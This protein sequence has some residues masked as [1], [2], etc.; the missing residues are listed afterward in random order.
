LGAS[1]SGSDRPAG[2]PRV[3]AAGTRLALCA[4]A[5][6]AA[7]V[8][9]GT[10]RGP[11]SA[12]PDRAAAPPPSRDLP[13][14]V[15]PTIG[16]RPEAGEEDPVLPLVTLVPS[17]DGAVTEALAAGL[18]LAFERS[19]GSGGPDLALRIAA[20]AARWSSAADGAVRDGIEA[21]A[22]AIV[23]P[24][25]R[26]HAHLLAQL[27]TRLRCPVLS[28]SPA[29]GV[30]AAGS[31]YVAAVVPTRGG[32]GDGTPVAPEFDAA[33]PAAAGFVEAFRAAHG[34]A[35][36]PWEAVGYDAGLCA[37]EAVRVHGL[38]RRGF[39]DAL[40]AAPPVAGAAWRL[41]IARNGSCR[42]EEEAGTAGSR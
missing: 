36:G 21:G 23:A 13:A 32:V 24:P 38:R 34:R 28:T 11:A 4:L 25:E 35:P 10:V 5:A 9:E 22:V 3:R 12:A 17:E 33:S 1:S 2:R 18:R 37:L 19:R 30:V 8:G 40:K 27:G 16:A 41:V 20:G 15:A 42:R 29:H 31:T 39:V 7:A 6:L 14:A 26:R